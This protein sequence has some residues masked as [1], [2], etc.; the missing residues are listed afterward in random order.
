MHCV[1]SLTLYYLLSTVT[2]STQEDRKWP[3]VT[4]KLLTGNWKH[5][6]SVP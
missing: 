2:G 3:D 4:E 6:Y 1:V 5:A